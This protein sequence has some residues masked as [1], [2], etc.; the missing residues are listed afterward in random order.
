MSIVSGLQNG[1]APSRIR[2]IMPRDSWLL[3]RAN[4]QP[5]ADD[6]ERNIGSTIGQFEA[7]AAATSLPDLFARLEE[8]G[9]LPPAVPVFDGERINLLMVRWCQPLFSTALIAYV[10]SHVSDPAEMNALCTA[11]P[12]PEKPTDWLPM[13]AVTLANGA[14]WRQH[15]GLNAWLMQCRLN[16]IA[17]TMRGVKA[18]DTAKFAL[19]KESGDKAGAAMAKLPAL[20]AA[21]G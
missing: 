12:S 3:D 16:S 2:W 17:A 7:I 13:W 19:L 15:A 4:G 9:L 5:G 10:E 1:V 14:R 6:F 21:T 8:R 18:D 11:V 20:L